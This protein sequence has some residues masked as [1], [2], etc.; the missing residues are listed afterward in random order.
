ML[1]SR[2]TEEK[3]RH[4]TIWVPYSCYECR[5]PEEFMNVPMHWHNEFEINFIVRGEGEVICDDRRFAAKEGDV[6]ILPPNMLHAA[7]PCRDGELVYRAFVFHPVMLGANSGERC[8]SECIRPLINGAKKMSVY[9][10]RDTRNYSEIKAAVGQIFSCAQSNQPRT[11]LLL[12]SELY[13]LF[14]L[15]EDGGLTGRRDDTVSYSAMIRPALEFMAENYQE[16]I[17]VARLA[18]LA[19]LSKSYF[20]SCFKKAVG[21]GAIEHLAQLRINAACEALNDTDKKIADIAFSCGYSNLSN[22]N[23]Q[24]LKMVG[25]TPNDYRKHT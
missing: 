17:S 22:F 20:M 24:F 19:H 14:W 25:C 21:I 9:I 18:D 1:P 6:L 10:S 23:R 5:L 12:K 16:N 4:S 13:R 2:E 7:Y 15:L 3:K 11:D 8:S